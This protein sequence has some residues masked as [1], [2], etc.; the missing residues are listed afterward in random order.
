MRVLAIVCLLVAAAAA[1][2]ST[3]E[4]FKTWRIAAVSGRE[5][6]SGFSR[7]LFLTAFR[8][9]CKSFCLRAA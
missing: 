5:A 8:A 4:E 7:T 1:T 6:V 9:S 3:L 2:A